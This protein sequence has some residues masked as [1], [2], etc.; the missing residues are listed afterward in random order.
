[1]TMILNVCATHT[2][3][4]LPP[5]RGEEFQRDA[6]GLHPRERKTS[7]GMRAA[8]SVLALCSLL[9]SSGLA[10]G[11]AGAPGRPGMAGNHQLSAGCPTPTR[12]MC[13]DPV[14]LYET[15]CGER[16][17][18]RSDSTCAV[19]LRN[20]MG[21]AATSDGEEISVVPRSLAN[22][23]VDFVVPDR[24]AS[25]GR[26]YVSDLLS[27][28]SQQA[29]SSYV[30]SVGFGLN[31]YEEWRNS[32][33]SVQS[34]R[35]YVWEK[36]A[37]INEFHRAARN[38]R[39]DGRAV[40]NIAF[41]P[42][43]DPASIGT[44]HLHDPRLRGRDGRVF[45]QMYVGT[46]Q[47]RN[48]FYAIPNFPGY[49]R[50]FEFPTDVPGLLDS[51]AA[52]SASGALFVQRLQNAHVNN[53]TRISETWGWHKSMSE[54]FARIPSAGFLGSQEFAINPPARGFFDLATLG[55]ASVPGHRRY[56]DDEL[57]ELWALQRRAEQLVLAWRDA[58]RRF[59]GSGWTVENAGLLPAAPVPPGPHRG[60][61]H[62]NSAPPRQG[63]PSAQFLAPVQLAIPNPETVVRRRILDELTEVLAIANSYGCL[64]GSDSPCDWSTR[65]F[66]GALNND[67]GANQDAAL[68][69]CNAFTNGNLQ[70]ILRLDVTFVDDPEYPQFNCS[71]S[72]G[73][74]ITALQ[75]E[76]LQADVEFCRQ[77]QIAVA[78]ERA[79]DE[80]IARIRAVPELV[81]PATGEVVPPGI[82]RSRDEY[83][84]NDYFALGYNYEIGF[85]S[86]I[87]A[88]QCQVQVRAIA[89]AKAFARVFGKEIILLDVRAEGDT[90]ARK[91]EIYARIASRNIFT[92][93]DLFDPVLINVQEIEPLE[94]N[95]SWT[96]D[97]VRNQP[98]I[99]TTIVVV[100]VPLKLTAG[101]A[102]RVGA[103]LGLSVYA[104]PA[105]NAGCPSVE[106]AGV[107][108][109]FLGVDGYLEAAINVIIA[110]FGIRGEL[111]IITVSL[112]FRPSIRLIVNSLSGDP[113]DYELSVSARMSLDLSTLSG[114]I[115]VFAKI[116]FCPLCYT[117]KRTIISWTGP[118]WSTQIFNQ[119]YRVTLGDLFTALGN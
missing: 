5:A 30:L 33:A 78:E 31:E 13:E 21:D 87:N 36:F 90:V 6:L 77:M 60:I 34:C 10:F 18:E 80:A 42:A 105:D 72:T 104:D 63:R 97:S 58:N 112:P 15:E 110:K 39:D 53:G 16:E 115:S 91:V 99:N 9:V 41:G 106:V 22:S 56:L 50:E 40:Y 37:D 73:N 64:N 100:I 45:G 82:Q 94:F 117:G 17:L 79:R 116:G 66:L 119:V 49:S 54:R 12:A 93:Q 52:R 7:T 92:P 75:F 71:I 113:D 67:Y 74:T 27:V 2:P 83:M 69:E 25:P 23:G 8:M 81:D 1:M 62:F 48:Y 19:L 118:S 65:R 86:G 3:S 11:Q 55:A 24:R 47:W 102:G 26:D 35:E 114:A 51:I 4:G 29:G 44:R 108:R 43:S 109:P 20:G 103:E 96:G 98:I 70:N 38:V 57:N 88:E 46:R 61:G 68:A 85:T 32:G 76:Q 95:L 28:H 89:R 59:V 14:F 111:N 101:I 84:G 107:V